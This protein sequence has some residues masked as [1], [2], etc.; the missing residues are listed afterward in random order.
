[1]YDY[2]VEQSYHYVYELGLHARRQQ[3]GEAGVA[4]EDPLRP[5][6]DLL[7]RLFPSYEFQEVDAQDFV[8]KVKIPSGDI[9]PFQDMSSGEKEVF[10]ILA[11]F[12]RNGVSRS[13][14]IIDEP[15]LHLHPELARKFIRQM[16]KIRPEN[17][18]W[19]ATHSADLID[20]A[21]RER[22]IYVRRKTADPSVAECVPADS[23]ESEVSILRDLFGYSGFVGISRRIVFSEGDAASADRKTFSSLFPTLSD[24]IKIIPVGSA[25]NLYRINR[26]I[27]ALLE[28]DFARCEFFLIRDRDY[29]S[30]QSVEK[31]SAIAPGRLFILERHQIENYL[32]DEDVLAHVLKSIFQKQV[33]TA[34]V[35]ASL[36]KIARSNSAA[37]LRDMVVSRYAELYQ[38][39]DCSIGNHSQAMSAIAATGE[40]NSGVLDALRASLR[41]RIGTVNREVAER[42]EPNA[43]D[44]IF[45]ACQKQVVA[46]L[47]LSKDDWKKL[48]PGKFILQRFA[49][50]HDLGLWPALQNLTI[51]AMAEMHP[52]SVSDLRMIFQRVA[53]SGTA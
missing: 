42:L 37:F 43:L 29:L 10:F 32:L 46:T 34:E 35:R 47:D 6:N 38:Q 27:L 40:P 22:T 15:E 12:I 26:A 24:D 16:R 9:I 49:K 52:R 20:E 17:Q 45:D 51:E 23:E 21:G 39:E 48:F 4:P 2:L 14:I 3:R 44:V 33:T 53:G 13:P 7:S 30:D 31:H 1:M 28:S 18:I 36:F 8:L 25:S 19:I 5:Y 41:E 50:E 11:F